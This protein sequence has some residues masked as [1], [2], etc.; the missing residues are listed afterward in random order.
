MKLHK[1]TNQEYL[2]L[3]ARI[4]PIL[5]KY[6]IDGYLSKLKKPTF[7]SLT[8]VPIS[9]VNDLIEFRDV[10]VPLQKDNF[11]NGICDEFSVYLKKKHTKT[12]EYSGYGLVELSALF[13]NKYSFHNTSHPLITNHLDCWHGENLNNRIDYLTFMIEFYGFIDKEE[14][15]QKYIDRIKS[16]SL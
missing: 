16:F 10:I 5:F 15:P 11:I 9:Y 2:N 3:G 12:S 4:N 7:D 8:N 6:G 14:L 1:T 13:Y